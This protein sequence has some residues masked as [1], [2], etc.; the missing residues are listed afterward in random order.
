VVTYDYN[1]QQPRLYSK[2]FLNNNSKIYNVTLANA[3]SSSSAAPTYFKPKVNING[4]NMSE[5][6]I[7]GGIIGNNPS[8]FAF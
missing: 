8:L 1:S 2:Y 5:Y 3:T 7:D 4:Y 6:L